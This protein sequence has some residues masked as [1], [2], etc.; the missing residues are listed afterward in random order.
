M[1]ITATQFIRRA[2]IMIHD[3][4]G[5]C[6]TIFVIGILPLMLLPRN[7]FLEG[8][9]MFHRNGIGAVVLQ[10]SRKRWRSI[11]FLPMLG[12]LWYRLFINVNGFDF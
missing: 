5:G 11:P 8:G 4:R 7:L 6:L 1:F 3:S 10:I 9:S 2:F 12:L